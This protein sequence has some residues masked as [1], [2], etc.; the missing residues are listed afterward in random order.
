MNADGA[1]PFSPDDHRF[2][3]AQEENESEWWYYHGHLAAA[4]RRFAFHLAFFRFRIGD[5]RLAGL[6]PLKLAA[7]HFRVAHFAVTELDAGKFHYGFKRSL[8]GDSGASL[9]EFRTWLDDWSAEQSNTGHRL[10]A[11]IEPAALDLTVAPLKPAI[12]RAADGLENI[13]PGGTEISFTRMNAAGSLTIGGTSLPVRGTA[14]MDREFGDFPLKHD[15]RGWDWLAIQLN[16]GTELRVYHRRRG[17][18]GISPPSSLAFVDEAGQATWLGESEFTLR[19]EARWTSPRTGISYPTTWSLIAA[20]LGAVLRIESLLRCNELD[21]RGSSNIIYWEGPAAVS[22]TLRGAE[23]TGRAF[24][25]LVGYENGDSPS[26]VFDFNG[27]SLRLWD[28]IFNEIRQQL[29]GRGV[30]VAD[31]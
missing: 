27:N 22:G 26:G 1:V 9:S 23:A 17:G 12:F 6:V 13:R 16:N 24:I 19:E 2:L 3:A 21:T 20:P 18:T 5:I 31:W 4:E 25:E 29:F 30:S 7:E 15:V 14:W 8:L 28:S 11:A 10:R